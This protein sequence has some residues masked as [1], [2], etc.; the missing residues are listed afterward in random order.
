MAV[1]EKFQDKVFIYVF[2]VNKN[3]LYYEN[4]DL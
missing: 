4:N 2:G 1:N 3:I